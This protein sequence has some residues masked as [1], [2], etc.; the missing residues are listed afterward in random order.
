MCF[1]CFSESWWMQWYFVCVR[2]NTLL[3]KYRLRYST[4]GARTSNASW[5]SQLRSIALV[6]YINLRCAYVHLCHGQTHAF[7]TVPWVRTQTHLRDIYIYTHTHVCVSTSAPRDRTNYCLALTCALTCLLYNVCTYSFT[8]L[9]LNKH[10]NTHTHTHTHSSS[11]GSSVCQSMLWKGINAVF[12]ASAGLHHALTQ[13]L[14]IANVRVCV[15]FPA[16]THKFIH[17]KY[18]V[19]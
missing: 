1:G 12:Q 18:K 19:P 15:S 3:N 11:I 9:S 2:K 8:V 13:V 10:K 14:N 6:C 16:R 17:R 5:R 4:T 7:S